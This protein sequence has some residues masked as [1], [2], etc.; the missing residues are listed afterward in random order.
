MPYFQRVP[1]AERTIRVLELLIGAPNGL[2]AGEMAAALGAPRSVLFALLNTLKGMGYAE[3]PTTRGPY[4]AGPR[5]YALSRPHPFGTNTLVFTF[6]EEVAGRS[7]DETV[8]LAVLDGSDVLIV[9]EAA[10]E[11]PVRSVLPTGHRAPAAESAAGRVLLAGLPTVTSERRLETVPTELLTTL[12][13]VR[14]QATA[15]RAQED[16][17][18]LAVP[19]CPDGY[20]PVA[21]LLASVPTFRWSR[22]AGDALLASLR[23]MAARISYRLGALVYRPYGLMAPRRLG[24][25][26]LMAPDELRIFLEGPW[27]AR[28]ACLRS[29]GSPHVVPVWYEW[30]GE[31][32]LVAAWPGSLWAGYVTHHPTVALTIDEPWPPMRRVLAQGEAQAISPGELPEGLEGLFCRLSVRYLGTPAHVVVPPEAPKGVWRA[33]RIVP[34][35]LTARREQIQEVP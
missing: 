34:T 22:A 28:L 19:I 31:A 26:V 25:T 35:R 7:F 18:E 16:T 13:E 32:F 27:A 12:A 14:R 4:R 24:P 17:V 10:C 2:T 6:Y 5:L 1:A 20:R 8:V 23:E 30:T 33:F 15:E 29:D 9:A 3:Q 21:A 11:R